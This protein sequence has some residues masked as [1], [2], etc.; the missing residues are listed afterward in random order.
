[1]NFGSLVN[2]EMPLLVLAS[3]LGSVSKIIYTAVLFMALC[4]TAVSHGFGILSE[5]HFS[6]P[7]HRIIAAALL[8]LLA[9]PFTGFGFSNLI[10][11]L[12]SA[13]GY[14]GFLWSGAVI[15]KYL[16]T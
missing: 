4:T 7:R 11:K 2:E 5:F 10:S 8:C 9:L 14:V 12:Y 6:S 3:R 1:M 15:W 16:K 13:F